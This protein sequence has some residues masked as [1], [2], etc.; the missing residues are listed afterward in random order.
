MHKKLLERLRA[1][2]AGAVNRM[3]E[4][5]KKTANGTVELSATDQAMFDMLTQQANDMAEQITQLEQ[6]MGPAPSAPP[7]TE[8]PAPTSA[9][10]RLS[11]LEAE[12]A[13]LK[14][15]GAINSMVS[16]AAKAYAGL[17]ENLALEMITAKLTVEQAAQR[18]VDEVANLASKL[19]EQRG[20]HSA[21]ITRDQRQTMRENMTAALLYRYK[22]REFAELGDK[23]RQYAGLSIAEMARTYL[24][25]AGVNTAGM[26]KNT[27]AQVALRGTA[28][29]E[30]LSGFHTTSDFPNILLDATNKTLRKGYQSAA[31]TFKAFMRQRTAT[32]FKTL[33]SIQISD[34]PVLLP[35]NE[36]G[37]YRRVSVSDSKES[38]ALGT[39]G[40][41]LAISRKVI[42]ND[43][44]DALT[45][46]PF[47]I[48]QAAARTE[49]NIAWG[50]I[51]ANA[52]LADSVAL[53]HSTHKNLITTNAL[54]NANLGKAKAAMRKQTAPK[55][56]KLS[57][58]PEFI[59]VPADLEHTTLQ[60]LNPSQ[61]YANASTSV[62]PDWIKN[63]K[64]IVESRLDDVASIG[65]TTW[66]L[67]TNPENVDT[68]EFCYLEGE[69]GVYIEPQVGWNVDGMEIKARIDFAAK[70]IDYRGMVRCDA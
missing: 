28:T 26:N 30:F 1:L 60:L 56:D 37:E 51:T 24:E 59:I 16:K 14:Y 57:L 62:V 47:Q 8:P 5:Q 54:N 9:E 63:L 10:E 18:I 15:E 38:Y 68:V 13:R 50:I 31:P 58:V 53:F 23:G 43:D 4:L 35:L 45:K 19:P 12:N 2:K 67:A 39:Y 3:T 48:G 29:A 69:E 17:P 46:I 41:M 27:V 22:P 65:A 44:L 25:A 6:E 32:D 11:R 49:S 34:A 70:A 33:N 7:T 55:G 21:S 20:H 42:I 36:H 66:Y 64:P 52:A 61:L 40:W